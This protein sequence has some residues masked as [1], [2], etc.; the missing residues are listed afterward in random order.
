LDEIYKSSLRS[1][2]AHEPQD[3]ADHSWRNG[4]LCYRGIDRN[5]FD[6]GSWDC[7]G[8]LV[9]QYIPFPR[10]PIT[11]LSHILGKRAYYVQKQTG[12][13]DDFGRKCPSSHSTHGPQ[14]CL[15]AFL[16]LF[17]FRSACLV[18]HECRLYSLGNVGTNY[19][20]GG[21]GFLCFLWY[22][23]SQIWYRSL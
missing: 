20:R 23:H 5:A 13:A 16:H 4:R 12:A 1:Q 7:I 6:I 10:F 2:V 8:Y 19:I 14:G 15:L 11:R 9:S 3:L 22:H 18:Y 17:N 21:D